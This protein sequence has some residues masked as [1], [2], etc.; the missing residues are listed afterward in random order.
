M[1]LRFAE[2]RLR[3]IRSAES[4]DSELNKATTDLVQGHSELTALHAECGNQWSYVFNV[5]RQVEVAT[6]GTSALNLVST[7]HKAA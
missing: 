7:S 5:E 4:F 1:L 3:F 2:D 6:A